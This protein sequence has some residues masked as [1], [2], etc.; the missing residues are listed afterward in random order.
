MYNFNGVDI[1]SRGRDP[2]RKIK[3]LSIFLFFMIMLLPATYATTS[4]ARPVGAH[5]VE[6]TNEYVKATGICS[7]GLNDYIYHTKAFKNYCPHC[8]SYGTLI[9]NP[10]G[11]PEGEWTCTKCS[12]DYCLADGNE[13]MPNTP[14]CL[15]PY[16]SPEVQAQEIISVKVKTIYTNLGKFKDKSF[17]ESVEI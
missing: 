10:K 17:L 6:I 16:N 13:K 1:I 9:F 2:Y 8:K 14:Y 11:V 3:Y 12:S 15:T 4:T 5:N 7:C